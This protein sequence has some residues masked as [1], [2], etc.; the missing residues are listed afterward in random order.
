MTKINVLKIIKYI[1]SDSKLANTKIILGGPEVRNHAEN[2][3]KYGADFL[4]LGEG[5]ET[6]L[7]LVNAIKLNATDFSTINGLAF[8]NEN[9]IIVNPERSLIKDINTL[10]FP[11]RYKID[12][13]NYLS[14]WKKHNGYSMMSVSTM[15]GCPYTC[16]WCSRAVYGGTYRRRSPQL[17][18]QE[19]KMLKQDYNPDMIWF[20]DDVFTI[21]HKWLNEFAEEVIKQ[22][23]MIPYE[24]ISRADRLNEEVIKTLK[25][26]GC[27]RVWVGAESGSQTII[28]AMDRRVDVVKTREM[29]Q[30]A[31][32]H[33]IEAGTFIMLGYPGESKKQIHETI[34][35]LVVANPSHYTITIAYPI[36][37]TQLHKDVKDKL[38]DNGLTWENSNDRNVDFER[39]HPKRYYEH[40][41]K[42]VQ[43]E[44]YLKTKNKNIL[45]IPYLKLKSLKYQ[46]QMVLSK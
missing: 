44:V 39:T 29:I 41:I 23:A 42:W 13:S 36:T 11:N 40:A 22:D 30:L 20:V 31:K 33:G 26:S 16:K 7:E 35:H 3:L 21:H 28:D 24:I 8:L 12:F 10:P 45:K 34:E 4:I 25:A 46:M 14:V 19:M 32:L 15:R 6:I 18:A 27:K 1:K 38:I 5:E 2:F 17:V 43:T 37:G 9:K